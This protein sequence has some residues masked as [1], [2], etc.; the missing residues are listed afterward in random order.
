MLHPAAIQYEH[1]MWT[2]NGGCWAIWQLQGM[3]YGMRPLKEKKAVRSAHQAL[4]RV[5]TGESMLLSV[6]VAQDPVSIVQNM[7]EGVDL[8]NSPAWAKECEARLD[9]LEDITMGDRLYFLCVPLPQNGLSAVRG[10]IEAEIGKMKDRLGLPRH[11][12]SEKE[13]ERRLAQAARIESL[14]PVTFSPQRVTVAH[15]RW[16][17]HHLVHRGLGS[18]GMTAQDTESVAA[19][20]RPVSSIVIDEGGQT[21]RERGAKLNPFAHRYVKVGTDDL[22][23]Q[24][25]ASYQSM[26]ALTGLPSGGLAWPGSELLGNIDS[27]LP[28]S[29]W[30]LRLRTR[31]SDAAKR[32]NKRA[33]SQIN[34]QLDQRSAE[35]GTGHHDLDEAIR[36]LTE[37]DEVLSQDKNEVEIQPTIVFAV[38]SDSAK[39]VNERA[40]AAIN[41]LRDE[42]FSV[43]MPA[44]YQQ[45]LWWAFVPG[46]ALDSKM[47]ELRLISTSKDLSGLVP[48]TVAKIGDTSGPLLG[49]NETTELAT[50]IHLDL[51]ALVQRRNVSGCVGVAGE[52]GSGKSGTQKSLMKPLVDTGSRVIATD[53]SE[54]GEWVKFVETLTNP[55][56]VD[57]AKPQYSLDPLRAFDYGVGSRIAS[58]F[59]TVLLDVT[60]TSPEGV[61]LSEVLE[62]EYLERE[63]LGGLGQVMEHLVKRGRDG[64]VEAGELGG[65]M[66]VF[67]KKDFGRV[68]FDESIPALPWRESPAIVIRTN[69]LEMPEN[70]EL[71]NEH[72]F[73]QM[74]IEKVFGRAAYTLISSLARSICFANPNEFAVYFE[75]EAH[76]VTRNQLSMSEI[77]QFIRDGRKHGAALVLGSHDPMADF[78][79]ETMRALIL[80]RIVHRQTDRSLA[81]RSLEWLGVDPDDEGLLD[82]LMKET[83]PQVGDE[84]PPER[85]GEA[86][87]RDGAGAIGRVRVLLPADQASRQAAETTPIKA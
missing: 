43:V 76:M 67:A 48:I 68:L 83:S 3:S 57:M 59:L 62:T 51:P 35:V 58:N 31:A 7:L 85:R 78:G 24:G 54:T 46:T 50:P 1:L 10:P 34:D 60:P 49:V 13:I 15:Q 19:P 42:E 40:M 52:L 6:V 87:I 74:K 81:Q 61:V 26:I 33:M 73:R 16:L 2:H 45:S 72:L 11:G 56:V 30:V 70:A 80:I 47:Q 38:C 29:D 25:Q 79:D 37:F 39:D 84:V 36:A 5:L 86:F 71:E 66:R 9:S 64:D 53:R 75:D 44:G 12:V 22:F 4:L 28:A 69:L 55:T 17:D 32:A 8:E 21:D 41:V 18:F 65:R 14:I 23:A 77:K 27:Y 63:Q 20:S 82:L